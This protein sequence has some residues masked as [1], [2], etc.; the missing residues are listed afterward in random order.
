MRVLGQLLRS[1]ADPHEY[2]LYKGETFR[3]GSALYRV[4]WVSSES[5]ALAAGVYRQPDAV[6]ASFKFAYD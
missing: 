4:N 2:V 6:R 5:S 1:D 3:I